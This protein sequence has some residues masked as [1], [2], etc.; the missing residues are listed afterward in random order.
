MNLSNENKTILTD[1]TQ[2]F[3]EMLKTEHFVKNYI[4][5]SP[6]KRIKFQQKFLVDNT[7][8]QFTQ[9]TRSQLANLFE[10]YVDKN[11]FNN[12]LCC[13]RHSNFVRRWKH[14]PI[15]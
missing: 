12:N 4:L 9:D 11:N 3:G 6:K 8:L 5:E 2:K 14:W 7:E 13:I 15:F 1:F 10:N